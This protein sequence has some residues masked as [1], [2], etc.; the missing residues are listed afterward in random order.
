[1]ERDSQ[2]ESDKLPEVIY[3]DGSTFQFHALTWDE[4]NVMLELAPAAKP[5]FD[6]EGD[7][8]IRIINEE[9]SGYYSR[10][11]MWPP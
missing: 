10:Q 5:Y 1:M 6:V 7:E 11:R 9:A 3:Q 8:V 2:Y 4:V